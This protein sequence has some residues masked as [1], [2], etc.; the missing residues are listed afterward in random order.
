MNPPADFTLDELL[1]YLKEDTEAEGFHTTREWTQKFG[2][3]A[4]RFRK[5][6]HEARA[7][8]ILRVDRVL[9][10]RIDGIEQPITVYAFDLR[11][12]EE[13]SPHKE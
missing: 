8:G 10:A 6:V 1:A 3:S 2:I 9:R 5:I 7:M 4:Y 11:T 12:D 13:R